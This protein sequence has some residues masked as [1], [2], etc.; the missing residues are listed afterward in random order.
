MSPF[1][2]PSFAQFRRLRPALGRALTATGFWGAV[3]LPL[4]SVPVLVAVS[5]P[6][7]GV[8]LLVALNVGCLLVGHRHDPSPDSRPPGRGRRDPDAAT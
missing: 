4:V 6:A 7:E 8:A 5:I 3:V 1:G 2:P